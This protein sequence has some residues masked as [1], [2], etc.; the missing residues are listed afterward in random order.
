MLNQKQI[1]RIN[2]VINDPV[3]GAEFYTAEQ[4]PAMSVL[5]IFQ[6]R[7]QALFRTLP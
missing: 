5:H 7:P 4:K 6:N 1:D 2:A 3:H